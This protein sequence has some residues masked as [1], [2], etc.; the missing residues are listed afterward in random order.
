MSEGDPLLCREIEEA[1]S[2]LALVYGENDIASVRS[3][4]MENCRSGRVQ[5]YIQRQPDCTPTDYVQY[6]LEQ[7]QAVHPV[8]D[9]LR[10]MRDEEAW[11]ALFRQLTRAACRHLQRKN[12]PPAI[13]REVAEEYVLAA[14]PALLE[15][16]FPYHSSF[17]SWAARVVQNTIDKGAR[18]LMAQKRGYG[19]EI[20]LEEPGIQ[21]LLQA[22]MRDGVEQ[23]VDRWYDLKW[24]LQQLPRRYVEILY[25]RYY[26]GLDFDE[27]ALA[28]ELSRAAT[29]ALH[30][31]AKKALRDLLA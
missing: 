10:I 13:L 19:R 20:D 26:Q 29:Y 23:S 3:V 12:F 17:E 4:L 8:V 31:R 24:A 9:R 15:G 21:R 25:L 7:Y 14:V 16:H 27:I 30:K 1:L 11:S 6:V 2:Q 18:H 28:L 22:M 5:H